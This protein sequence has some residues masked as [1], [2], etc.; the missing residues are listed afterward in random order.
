M[1]SLGAAAIA[2]LA[3]LGLTASFLLPGTLADPEERAASGFDRVAPP[4][5]S[6]EPPTGNGEGTLGLAED[7]EMTGASQG[8]GVGIE[9]SAPAPEPASFRI[10]GELPPSSRI[11]VN[12]EEMR[13]RTLSLRPG[14]YDVEIRATGY[15]PSRVTL[16]LGAGDD[17]SWRPRFEPLSIAQA[18]APRPA[19]ARPSASQPAARTAP[20]PAEPEP[21]VSEPPEEAAPVDPEAE[22]AAL[23][24]LAMEAVRGTLDRLVQA[25]QGRDIAQ[26]QTIYPAMTR[27]EQDRWRQF[28]ESDD[29]SDL[30]VTLAYVQTPVVH[31]DLAETT[32]DIVLQFR[33]SYSGRVRQPTRYGA[34]LERG[35]ASW[36]IRNMD[37]VR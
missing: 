2:I 32:F 3:V 20:P 10:T 34:T 19:G 28:L 6:R 1:L 12:G 17:R 29:I 35:D 7:G 36:L 23:R 33:S 31:G 18:P 11:F 14:S 9:E 30:Q 22:R 27:A 15:V 37:V 26:L 13:R 5:D 4:T 8:A 21:A 16:T 25:L 24:T